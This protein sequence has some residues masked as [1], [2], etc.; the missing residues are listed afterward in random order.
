MELKNHWVTTNKGHLS[1]LL[2]WVNLRPE[3]GERTWMMFAFYMTV[4][5]GLRWAEDSTIA[6]FLEQYGAT[7]LPWIYIASAVLGSNL[8]F[9][10]SWLQKIFPLRWVIVAIIPLMVTP[11]FLLILLRWEMQVQFP[12]IAMIVIFL[13]KIWAD[14]FM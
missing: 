11:L 8:V 14:A 13:L 4:S 2:Q 7:Q 6:L 12:S 1:R 3:E 5:V 10:Y 9:L